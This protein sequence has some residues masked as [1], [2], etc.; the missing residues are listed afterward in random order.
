MRNYKL[1]TFKYVFT[2]P[3]I[4]L[5][6]TCLIATACLQVLVS[7]SHSLTRLLILHIISSSFVDSFCLV[8]VFNVLFLMI[9]NRL[10]RMLALNLSLNRF[11]SFFILLLHLLFIA[12]ILIMRQAVVYSNNNKKSLFWMLT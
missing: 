9:I 6:R 5:L 11:N 10:L 1:T 8:L 4:Y 3:V 2:L 12:F 7:L